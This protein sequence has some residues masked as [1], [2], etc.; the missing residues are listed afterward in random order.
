MQQHELNYHSE[1]LA[2]MSGKHWAFWY[3]ENP[4]KAPS[5]GLGSDALTVC[6]TQA[7]TVAVCQQRPQ[8]GQDAPSSQAPYA[9]LLLEYAWLPR[10][11]HA[12]VRAR[13][14]GGG[15]M[16][17]S[18]SQPESSRRRSGSAISGSDTR[19][20]PPYEKSQAKRA[21]SIIA[22]THHL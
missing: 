15:S 13:S 2:F 4:K 16:S 5:P 1:C 3:A 18:M 20:I 9:Q 22:T 8:T 6:R 17:R 7:Y 11:S 19:G 10:T 21:D 12:L 14:L